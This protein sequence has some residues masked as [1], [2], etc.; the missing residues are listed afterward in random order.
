MR[1]D[2]IEFVSKRDNTMNCIK[3]T[4]LK[5]FDIMNFI[6][7]GFN[8]ENFIK[9]CNCELQKGSSHMN[10]LLRLMNCMKLNF[11]LMML[12]ILT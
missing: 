5:F 7:P 2:K 9:A 12:S 8:Y 10:I 11:H 6:A 1:H 3:T 4:H